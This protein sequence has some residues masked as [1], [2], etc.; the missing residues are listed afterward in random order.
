MS[1]DELL[2]V[3]ESLS[4]LAAWKRKHG[5]I[6]VMEDPNI[7]GTESPDSGEL[8]AAFYCMR[9]DRIVN[10]QDL[11]KIGRGDTEDEAC[12]DYAKRNDLWHWAAGER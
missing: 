6:T 2:S 11:E 9:D 10:S 4:P 7:V 5:L 12:S 1:N 8:C 3:G